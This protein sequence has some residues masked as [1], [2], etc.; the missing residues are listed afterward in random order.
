MRSEASAPLGDSHVELLAHNG[1]GFG[2]RIS[3]GATRSAC[4]PT[5]PGGLPPGA[6]SALSRLRHPFAVR[7][8]TLLRPAIVLSCHGKWAGPSGSGCPVL[9]ALPTAARRHRVPLTPDHRIAG[10]V[11]CLHCGYNHRTLAVGGVCP[12]C[13]RAV[14]DTLSVWIR[15]AGDWR[16]M[17]RLSCVVI[18]GGL[19]LLPD[20]R[21][22]ALY[23]VPAAYVLLS[24]T[25]AAVLIP[26]TA[27]VHR[28]VRAFDDRRD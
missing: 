14:L 24:A 27:S 9:E 11:G 3:D 5:A 19:A 8:R 4:L 23:I 1:A 15:D 20:P 12:E 25:L 13:G 21:S 18:L 2:L 28:A 10:D 22:S 16:R 6:L 26:F 7:T 17:V